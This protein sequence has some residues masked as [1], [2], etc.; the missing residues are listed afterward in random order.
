MHGD[1][2]VG[3]EDDRLGRR[4]FAALIARQ[5][6][7]TRPREGL[8]IAVVGRWGS[9]KT[10]VLRMVAEELSETSDANH[11]GTN[12]LVVVEFNPWLFSGSEQ[13]T[14]LFF[15][16]LGDQLAGKLGED[17]T[18]KI[19]D[20][21]RRY[22]AAIGTLRALPGIG[23]FF[24]AGADLAGEAARR[25]DTTAVDLA[26]QRAAVAEALHELD[27]HLVVLIDDVDRLQTA[28]EIRDLM[29]M[30]KLVGDLPGVTYVLSYDRRPVVAALTSDAISGEEYLE[31]IVQ[32]EH[33]L[34]EVARDRLTAML[35]D[36]LN[37]AISDLPD[38]RLDADRLPE[39]FAKIIEP[40]VTTP[41]HVRRY[42]NA[43]HLTLDLH[44]DEVDL[45]DQ[46]A[47]TAIATFV[48]TF[49]SRLP[50]LADALLGGTG[51][52]SS[53][54]SERRKEETKALL[55]E[56]ANSCSAPDVALAA[57]SL[58]FPRTGQVLNN[59]ASSRFE[60]RDAQRW[61]RVADAE[62][63]WT[64]VTAALPETGI[65]VAEVRNALDAMRDADAL[66]DILG[67]RDLETLARL[68]DRLRA[69]VS[70][71]GIDDIPQAAR[72]IVNH[73][74]AR[75]GSVRGPIDDPV[76]QIT[77][78]VVDLV[79]QLP[80]AVRHE[81]LTGWAAAE[82][83]LEAKLAIYEISHYKTDRGDRLIGNE[84]LVRLQADIADTVCT[85]D[86]GELLALPDVGRLFWL[87]AES[88]ERNRLPELQALLADDRTFVRY[89]S[90]FTEVSFDEGPR[91]LAWRDLTESL[92]TEWLI[93]RVNRVDP[94]LSLPEDQAQVLE[95]ARGRAAAEQSESLEGPADPEVDE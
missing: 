73:V 80:E 11:A 27:I 94:A 1:R 26:A 55:E 60:Q 72:V 9:G 23:G 2:P 64:Y 29:R 45:V 36:E 21:L 32:I 86:P 37:S 84:N 7:V 74:R 41:R 16:T 87:T 48:P 6:R 95:T 39:I 56:A 42:G 70:E 92:G 19:A 79:S 49:H 50:S 93:D 30:V 52:L 13:L 77:W 59:V 81:C 61:R 78:F 89:L 47:L 76:R 17:R 24:G 35:L 53:L 67:G 38:D 65:R 82:T 57:Y 85:A 69:H 31:K 91:P 71:V 15:V 10:S 63:F 75:A 20:R 5:I 12:E 44:A 51:V 3:R 22:G 46:L 58:L 8:V 54:F 25:L 28:T 68:F 66:N 18:T 33:S 90:V 43:L 4:P 40:V 88:L 34:P 14:A 83:G 62:A